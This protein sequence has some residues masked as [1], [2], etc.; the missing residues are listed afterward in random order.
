MRTSKEELKA[1]A[2]S[3][4][5][6]GLKVEF[7]EVEIALLAGRGKSISQAAGDSAVV[8]RKIAQVPH[9]LC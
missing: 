7:A 4:R 1:K 2:P 3:G 9:R 6:K 5:G 8:R